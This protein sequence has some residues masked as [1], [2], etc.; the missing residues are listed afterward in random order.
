MKFKDA[1]HKESYLTFIKKAEVSPGDVERKALFYLLALDDNTRANINSLYDFRAGENHIKPSGINAEWQTSGACACTK[2]AYNLYN[3]FHG[4][5]DEEMDD[6]SVINIFAYMDGPVNKEA[7][8][9]AIRIRFDVIDNKEDTFFVPEESIE[10]KLA[11][12]GF[13]KS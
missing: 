7:F 13:K 3:S 10:S 12:M 8:F 4:F 5:K 9:E 2:L 11:K 1:A 6:Y